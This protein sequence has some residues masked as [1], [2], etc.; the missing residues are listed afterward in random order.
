MKQND[1]LGPSKTSIEDSTFCKQDLADI[2][3]FRNQYKIYQ[4]E[5][6]IQRNVLVLGMSQWTY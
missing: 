4:W 3:R 5:E 6:V 1:K 2:K